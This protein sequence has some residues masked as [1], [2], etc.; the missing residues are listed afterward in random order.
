MTAFLIR[1]SGDQRGQRVH[2][3]TL[4]ARLGRHPDCEVLIDYASVSRE[5]ARIVSEGG[6]LL[7]E[8]LKSRNGTLLNGE[9]IAQRVALR[10]GDTISICGLTFELRLKSQDEMEATVNRSRCDRDTDNGSS[11]FIVDDDPASSL[12]QLGSASQIRIAES[13]PRYDQDRSETK[14]RALLDIGRDLSGGAAE[15]LPKVLENLMYIFPQADCAYIFLRNQTTGQLEAKS[16]RSRDPMRQQEVRASRSIIEMVASSQSAILSDDVANDSRFDASESIVNYHINTMMAAPLTSVDGAAAFGVVQVDCRTVGKRFNHD[17]LDLLVSIAFQIATVYQNT[18]LQEAAL[19][20]QVFQRELSVA[21]DV[22]K[23]LLPYDRPK[24][25]GYSFFDYYSPAKYLGGDYYDYISLPDGRLVLALGDVSGKGAP[26]SLL[27]AKL[28]VEVRTGLLGLTDDNFASCVER[29]NQ[30]YAHPRWDDRFITFFFSVLDPKTGQLTFF[31]AGHVPPILHNLDGSLKINDTGIGLPLG[32]MAESR[33][34][35]TTITLEPG[36][37]MVIISDGFTDAMDANGRYWGMSGVTQCLSLMT[38]LRAD[39]L[40]ERLVA[41]VRGFSG[42]VAQTDD[43]S[44]LVFGRD[45]VSEHAS[46]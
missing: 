27:M 36:Q 28:S 14:L 2:L 16:F 45:A 17:D 5:H 24:V 41:A 10:D 42:R 12:F 43:Q 8:D 35:P 21:H 6:E 23:C 3:T 33:Y 18:L 38:N 26:A 1:T 11:V 7:L 46:T 30:L 37:T 40:G 29:L 19:R 34:E 20:E 4:P 39:T 15:V 31:N 44:L 13:R 32:I 22:Q 25:P 9:T